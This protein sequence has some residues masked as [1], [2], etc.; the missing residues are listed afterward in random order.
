MRNYNTARDYYLLDD[1]NVTVQPAV[2]QAQPAMRIAVQTFTF[3][4]LEKP[5]ATFFL[6]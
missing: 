4:I 6:Q 3:A 2:K 5:Q 1:A